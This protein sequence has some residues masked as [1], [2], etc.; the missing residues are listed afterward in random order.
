[1]NKTEYCPGFIAC[2]LQRAYI[3]TL[4]TLEIFYYVVASKRNT[5]I[6]DRN[7]THYFFI[8]TTPKVFFHKAYVT[9]NHNSQH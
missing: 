1:M 3:S 4:Q 8:V 6:N 7:V 5:R 9:W 2:T